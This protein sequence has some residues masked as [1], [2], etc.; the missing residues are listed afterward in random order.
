MIHH[1]YVVSDGT[2]KT[3]REA[4]RAAL[5]QFTETEVTI[6]VKPGIRTREEILEHVQ[7]ASAEG[8]F[9][10][11]TLVSHDLREYLRESAKFCQ[12]EAIDLMGP[13]LAQLSAQFSYKPTEQPGLFRELNKAYFQRIEAMEF[14]FRHDDGQRVDELDKAEI[15]LMGASR[16]FKTPLSIYFAFK[17]W[18]VA[19][20]PIIMN[21]P[22][23]EIIR[24]LP[25]GR[26]IGLTTDPYNLASLRKVRH[27]HLGGATGD[28]AELEYVRQEILFASRYFRDEAR[29][30]VVD[31]TRKPIEEIAF[32]I[33][34]I[35]R[36]FTGITLEGD[37][38]TLLD[39]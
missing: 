21:M 7:E 5:T 29:C 2:G 31:V 37:P 1:I 17:G 27:S 16:T 18:M 32:E 26:V 14:A 11:H 35:L 19:N 3:A 28:Y 38:L 30:P 13:L 8:A 34:T 25:R 33:I 24:T 4:L 9:I 39:R 20:V 22:P 36:E 23:A 15:V 6:D 10:I 12:I